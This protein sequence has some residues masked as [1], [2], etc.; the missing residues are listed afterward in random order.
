MPA[1]GQC[2]RDN[3][4]KELYDQM[5]SAVPLST[6]KKKMVLLAKANEYPRCARILPPATITN[7][8]LPVFRLNEGNERKTSDCYTRNK[9]PKRL[10]TRSL[11]VH[12]C[13]S[14]DLR[15]SPQRP[16]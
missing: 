2:D 7:Y 8:R 11:M 1:I 9:I 13:V 16:P 3:F 4:N 14:R 6:E 12:A 15:Q 5:A 10:H